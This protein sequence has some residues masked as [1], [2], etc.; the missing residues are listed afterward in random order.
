MSVELSLGS[1]NRRKRLAKRLFKMS[2]MHRKRLQHI[3]KYLIKVSVCTPLHSVCWDKITGCHWIC[4]LNNDN[5]HDNIHVYQECQ[6][7]TC[8]PRPN[9]LTYERGINF[10][11]NDQVSGQVSTQT[12]RAGMGNTRRGP[13]WIFHHKMLTVVEQFSDI[14]FFTTRWQSSLKSTS[15]PKTVFLH[16][17]RRARS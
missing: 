3:T 14:T 1:M 10:F 6:L 12:N 17:R 16:Q 5:K 4:C 2:K 13:R 11:L 7:A 9:C 8:W 15:K